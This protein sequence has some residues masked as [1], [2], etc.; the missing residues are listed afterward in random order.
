MEKKQKIIDVFEN[1][2]IGCFIILLFG[3][4]IYSLSVT[5][6]QKNSEFL[7]DDIVENVDVITEE[8]DL[9]F[10]TQ[11]QIRGKSKLVY[12]SNNRI[13]L[14]YVKGHE[15]IEYTFYLDSSSTRSNVIINSFI[16]KYYNFETDTNIEVIFEYDEPY[17]IK[18]YTL[19]QLENKLDKLWFSTL[20]KHF[21][22]LGYDEVRK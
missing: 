8:I 17:K 9:D 1:V 13:D 6:N 18:N 2:I 4:L 15:K 12:T 10:D 5:I 7:I 11:Q 21:T 3:I 19:T 16:M 22:D 20:R 14:Q